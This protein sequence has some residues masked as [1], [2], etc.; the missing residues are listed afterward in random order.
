MNA[1][2]LLSAD[3]AP[4]AA[5]GWWSNILVL[6]VEH[7]LQAYVYKYRLSSPRAERASAVTV[8]QCPHSGVGQDFLLRRKVPLTET[9]VTRKR[10]V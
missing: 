7:L 4:C 3:L 8:R 9:A 2:D 10:K 6:V 5:R 1:F